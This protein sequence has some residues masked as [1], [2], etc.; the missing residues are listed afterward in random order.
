MHR[1]EDVSAKQNTAQELKLLLGVQLRQERIRQ[2]LE[3]QEVA[4]AAGV[5]RSALS[6]V[7]NGQ[8]GTIHT[9]VSITRA[10][11]RTDWLSMLSPQVTVQPMDLI[12][13]TRRAPQRVRRSTTPIAAARQGDPAPD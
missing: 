1:N 12:R 9:L 7:E 3:Q 6:R 8:G 5:A 10:L 2:R 13:R 11:G 4:A